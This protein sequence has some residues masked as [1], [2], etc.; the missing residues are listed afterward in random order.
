M[1]RRVHRIADGRSPRNP[2]TRPPRAVQEH[3]TP[4]RRF[5]RM[6]ERSGTKADV[7]GNSHQQGEGGSSFVASSDIGGGSNAMSPMDLPTSVR[8]HWESQT[9]DLYR[10]CQSRMIW[11]TRQSYPNRTIFAQQAEALQ[12]PE[13]TGLRSQLKGIVLTPIL[14]DTVPAQQVA[15]FLATSESLYAMTRNW[16]GCL[17]ETCRALENSNGHAMLSISGSQQ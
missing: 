10:C 4:F 16:T 6:D 15:D 3:F 9:D 14:A 1:S 8:L 7:G 5:S 12:L 17:L 2:T 11:K 13:Y